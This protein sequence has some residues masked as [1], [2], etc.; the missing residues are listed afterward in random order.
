[1]KQWSFIPSAG[2]VAA[3]A[4]GTFIGF[5]GGMQIVRS[6]AIPEKDLPVASSLLTSPVLYEWWASAEGTLI[7]KKDDYIILEQEGEQT[8]IELMNGVSQRTSFSN[9]LDNVQ[10]LFG[11]VQLKDIPLGAQL[12]GTVYISGKEPRNQQSNQTNRV[13]GNDF[14]VLNEQ[15]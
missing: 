7:E 2:V 12:R 10:E 1:M 6:K 15:Q 11:P 5:V 13:L 3:F 4:F 14:V 9:S 8:R